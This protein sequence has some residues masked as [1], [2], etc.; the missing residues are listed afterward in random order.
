MIK[1]VWHFQH[2]KNQLCS[3]NLLVLLSTNL[4]TTTINAELKTNQRFFDM[5]K[6]EYIM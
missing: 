2:P 1:K 4:F 5:F 3:Q 6:T